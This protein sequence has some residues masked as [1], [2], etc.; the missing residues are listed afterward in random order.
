MKKIFR[1]IRRIKAY[2]IDNSWPFSLPYLVIFLMG[3]AIRGIPEFLVSW[4]PIG[5]ETITY[6]APPLLEF[7]EFGFV[8]VFFGFFVSG[9]LF[10]LLLWFAR[11]ISGAHPYLLLKLIGPILY[12]GLAVSFMHFLTKGLKLDKKMAFVGTLIFIFQVATLRISWD[13]FRNVLGLIFLFTT[14]TVFRHDSKH[15]W[16]FVGLFAVLTAFSREY[17]A[18]L[19]FISILGYSIL[20]RKERLISTIVLIPALVVFSIT[21]FLEQLWIYIP[22]TQGM[23]NDYVWVAKD[24]FSI[25]AVCFLPLLP[26]VV[27]G[28]KRENLIDPM[29]VWLFIGSFSVIVI[30]W[31][32]VPG[33]QR[34][35]VLLVIPFTIYSIKGI[36]RFH[37][38]DKGNL[39]KLVT[40]LLVFIIIGAGYS[41]GIFSSLILHNSWVPTN[42]M[43]TSI[44]W[45]QIDDVKDV[46]GWFDE[47]AE[48]NSILL[49]EERFYGWTMIYLNRT[50]E[51][52]SVI[53]YGANSSPQYVL[54]EA[55][56][57][58]FRCIYIIWYTDSLLTNF[59]SIYSQNN[60]SIFRYEL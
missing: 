5:Y 22:E 31:F 50:K 4:Y 41:I 14:L 9:P 51:D 29:L 12:G 52:V 42:L 39:K 55:L 3:V 32:A 44:E 35:I 30:P 7:G 49:S 53:G 27:K 21:I 47:N 20:Q 18:F 59:E 11:V 6:Y 40:V 46:L 15:R 16:W 24:V 57:N 28:F 33:Y 58:G 26:F 43:Q 19:L 13:R 45:N 1:Y 38:L 17:I 25:F 23:W 8:E 36:E 54:D 48:I 56:I 60:I 34:W 2:A 37:L 10:Y